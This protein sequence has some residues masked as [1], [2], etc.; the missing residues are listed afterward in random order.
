MAFLM[1]IIFIISVFFQQPDEELDY[2]S[3]C[4]RIMDVAALNLFTFC[5]LEFD[6]AG[7]S[8]CCRL[9]ILKYVQPKAISFKK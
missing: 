1:S 4:V 2:V 9:N 6:N 5:K 7:L 3:L 8:I